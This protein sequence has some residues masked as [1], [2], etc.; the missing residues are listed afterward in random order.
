MQF[1]FLTYVMLYGNTKLSSFT[2]EGMKSS[3]NNN[4]SLVKTF[5]SK[6]NLVVRIFLAL[7]GFA[8]VLSLFI[9]GFFSLFDKHID[10]TKGYKYLSNLA[11]AEVNSLKIHLNALKPIP[12]ENTLVIPKIGV[13]TQIHEG[14]SISTLNKGIWHRPKT[15]SPDLGGNTVLAGHRY[16]YTEGPNTFYNLDKLVVGDKII[17]FWKGKEYDYE[18]VE[19]KVVP[20]TAIEIEDN[21]KD[22]LLT[23]YT[24]TPLF[25]STDRLVVLAKLLKA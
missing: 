5:K 10:E 21:T 19:T 7:L 8:L 16:L 17:I 18:I 13:D 11:F 9:P 22:P 4:F 12:K 23:I 2:F 3:E 1:T 25:T 24:C 6:L 15:S 14:E 20:P